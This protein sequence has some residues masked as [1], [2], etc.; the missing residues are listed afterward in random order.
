M[1]H[2]AAAEGAEKEESPTFFATGAE[3]GAAIGWPGF[4]STKTGP[5]GPN[6][7]P[8]RLGEAPGIAK[9]SPIR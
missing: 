3:R 1:G 4:G 8:E 2:G 9:P 7:A 6:V 5:Q